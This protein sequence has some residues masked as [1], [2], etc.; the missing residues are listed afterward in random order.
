M[1]KSLKGLLVVLTA[2][3]TVLVTPAVNAEPELARPSGANPFLSVGADPANVDVAA[4]RRYLAQ[5][6]AKR[7]KGFTAQGASPVVQEKEPAGTT[8]QNDTRGQAEAI[9]GFGSSRKNRA[10]IQGQLADDVDVYRVDLRAGDVFA[11]KVEGAGHQ[12][13]IFDPAGVQR[14]GSAQDFSDIFPAASPLPRGGNAIA[15]HVAAVSGPHYLAV[16]QGSGA[17]TVGIQVDRPGL[18]RDILP[19]IIFLDF[20]GAEVDTAIFG[21]DPGPHTLS[22]FRTFL[23]NWGLTPADEPAVVRQIVR[24]VRENLIEDVAARSNNP[25]ARLIV[26]N[27]L[28]HP[29]LF[30]QPNVSR[31]V[32]GGTVEELGFTTIGI[33]QSIDPGNFA[34]EETAVVLQDFLSQPAGPA[35]SL[36]TYLAPQSNRVEF[37]G[38]AVANVISH[39]IGHYLGSWHTDPTNAVVNL[40]DAGGAGYTGMFGTGPD[41]I[42]G[43]ADDTDTDLTTSDVFRP[44]EGFTGFEDSLNR[45]AFGLAGFGRPSGT[46]ATG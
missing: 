4:W 42:G 8:G 23:A 10:T 33:A 43:T 39:E 18:E 5:Q 46:S 29:D 37:V 31:V 20:N 12:L 36:N 28:D 44:S 6:S 40:M 25:R 13:T 26:L 35:F 16:A 19:Q 32:V 14:Q 24:T 41:N 22:P 9:N 30:G 2:G 3:A 21:M 11:A 34:Q 7:A 15:D 1:G 45:T 27:S 38:R 17:Y